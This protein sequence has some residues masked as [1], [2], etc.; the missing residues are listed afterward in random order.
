MTFNSFSFIFVFLPLT[1]MLFHILRAKGYFEYAKTI[2]IFA[3]L[4]FY[5]LGSSAS[6][7]ILIISI[8]FNYLMGLQIS[9][10]KKNSKYEDADKKLKATFVFALSMNL[11]LLSYYKYFSFLPLGISFFTIMLIMYIVDCFQGLIKPN[12]LKNHLLDVS[13]FP[14]VVM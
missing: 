7:P 3:S 1:L 4:T 5:S 10:F 12:N 2:I 9:S 13:F 14:S 8:L 6:L 11:I